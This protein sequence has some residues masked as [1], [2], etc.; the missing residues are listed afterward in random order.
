[1]AIW[2]RK[3]SSWQNSFQIDRVNRKKKKNWKIEVKRESLN[4]IKR[5][6]GRILK[7]LSVCVCVC[8]LVL[9]ILFFKRNGFAMDFYDRFKDLLEFSPQKL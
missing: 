3:G 2:E 4:E 1:M 9:N 5:V 8:E 6:E 7:D